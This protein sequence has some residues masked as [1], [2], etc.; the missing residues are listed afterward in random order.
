MLEVEL[1]SEVL[2]FFTIEGWS[3]VSHHNSWYAFGQEE[4][5]QISECLVVVCQCDRKDE[6]EFGEIICND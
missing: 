1:S 4:I 5:S 6:R 3:I 2:K